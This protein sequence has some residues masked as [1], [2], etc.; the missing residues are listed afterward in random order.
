MTTRARA[1]D[2][3]VNDA[4]ARLEGELRPPWTYPTA[5]AVDVTFPAADVPRHVVHGLGAVPDGFLVLLGT[6]PVYALTPELWTEEMALVTS[7]VANTFA[8][9]WFLQLRQTPERV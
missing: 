3:D 5:V 7:P 2:A 1:L 8:R 4:L 6:G 9:L